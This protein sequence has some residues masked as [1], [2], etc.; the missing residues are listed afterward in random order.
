MLAGLLLGYCV[1]LSYGLPLLG[2]LALTVL[3]LARSWRPLPLA[4]VAALAVV[5]VF[6]AFGF[7]YLEALPA[8]RDRYWEGVAGAGP[9]RTGCGADRPLS[10]SPP[11]RCSAPAR[12]SPTSAGAA[13]A[14]DGGRSWRWPG[15]PRPACCSQTPP[16]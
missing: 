8:I 11:V 3:W 14:R 15:R 6:A 1:M 13:S 2:V 9:R 7:S 16:R 5:A 10:S 4:V 12:W